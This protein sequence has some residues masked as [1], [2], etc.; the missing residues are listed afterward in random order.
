MISIVGGLIAA[1][2]WAA[3][4][5][6]AAL[7]GRAVGPMR[8]LAWVN[9]IAAAYIVPLAILVDGRPHPTRAGVAWAAL[10]GV[11][12]VA[13]LVCA[14]QAMTIGPVGLVGPVASTEGA[15][16]AVGGVL[17]GDAIAGTTG[18]ALAVVVVG[19]VLSGIERGPGGV[20]AIRGADR[21]AFGW[22]VLA[23]LLFGATL[24]ASSRAVGFG[25]ITTIA[26][27]RVVASAT[28]STPVLVRARFARPTGVWLIVIANGV[29]DLVGFGAYIV[30]SRHGVAVPAVL[31]SQY[32]TITAVFGYLVFK[33]RLGRIQWVGVALAIGGTA[34]VAATST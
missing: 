18:I 23:A 31:G 12:M 17:L 15:I 4:G 5:L 14:F 19:I 27:G 11:V 30:A 34:I 8:A 3:A 32:A 28:F 26:I 16:A 25:A 22:A 10:Y 29:L 6:T 21:R 9:V 20:Q 2:C 33:E 24:V 13:A 1:V 7:A